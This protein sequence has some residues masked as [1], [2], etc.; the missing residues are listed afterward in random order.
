MSALRSR[1]WRI[2]ADLDPIAVAGDDG[3]LWVRD[4][5]V[6]A[7]C[8]VAHDVE[9]Q[10]RADLASVTAAVLDGIELDGDVDRTASGPLAFGALPFDRDAPA[11]MVV[12]E[13]LVG[14]DRDKIG[15]AHV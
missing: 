10:Q 3:V 1:V 12:P 13:L 11:S 8:G 7:G 14:R 15:R 9:V 6:L 5:L 4:G 2:D